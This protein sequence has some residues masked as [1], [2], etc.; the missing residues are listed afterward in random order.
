MELGAAV[1]VLVAS[2]LGIPI[3]MTLC[4]VGSVVAVGAVRGVSAVNWALFRNV[5][6]AWLLTFPL[7]GMFAAG[8][9]LVLRWGFLT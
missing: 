5:V 1:T 7:S 4:V 2:K 8:L 9:M 3:S 6:F